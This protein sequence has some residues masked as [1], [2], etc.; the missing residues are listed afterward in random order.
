M[1]SATLGASS[2]KDKCLQYWCFLLLDLEIH[3]IIAIHL[4]YEYAF[5]L[6]LIFISEEIKR[7]IKIRSEYSS[8]INKQQPGGLT[9]DKSN[10]FPLAIEGAKGIL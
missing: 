6:Y 9:Q 2:L 5:F 7:N 3:Q 1:N 4:L 10:P 8:L